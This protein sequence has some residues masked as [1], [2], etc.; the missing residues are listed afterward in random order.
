[1]DSFDKIEFKP[2]TEGL[3]FHNK[4]QKLKNEMEKSNF[5]QEALK[6]SV[7]YIPRPLLTEA[8]S[9][10]SAPSYSPELTRPLPR[11]E[12]GPAQPS[13]N[14]VVN[15]SDLF[16]NTKARVD[17]S[18]SNVTSN[19]AH[20]DVKKKNRLKVKWSL[21]AAVLD[22]I[23]CLATSMLFLV[24]VLAITKV[25]LV[26]ILSVDPYR[27]WT[28]VSLVVLLI[29]VS[30]VYMILTRSFFGRSLGEWA[31][32]LKLGSEEDLNQT[33]YP[34]KVAWRMFL[35]TVSGFIVF[36]LLSLIFGTDTLGRLT[37]LRLYIK[38]N[39]VN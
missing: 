9:E 10:N 21:S 33:L 6:D 7:P 4:I 15:I 14:S 17:F 8:L 34:L 38:K 1:M 23:L 39:R 24:S 16:S 25:N 30:H 19:L 2:M 3:G 13:S 18:S 35:L 29:G 11:P 12:K 5:A 28:L 22:F 26:A 27:F 37:G 32:D 31:F 36:P 20:F